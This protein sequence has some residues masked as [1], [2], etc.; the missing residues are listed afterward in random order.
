MATYKEYWIGDHG[1]YLYDADRTYPDTQPLSGIRASQISIEDT[2][3]E[4]YHVARYS[5][6][7][8]TSDSWPVDS[9]FGTVL[10]SATAPFT[11]G[12]WAQIGTTTI[13]T[14]TVYWWKRT[15]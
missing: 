6:L 9:V 8:P 15:A 10:F 11:F 14:T 2:P 13:G 1:P 4:S 5:D 7:S 3:S 12:T